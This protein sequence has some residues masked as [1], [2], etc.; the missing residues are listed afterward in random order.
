MGRKVHSLPLKLFICG[1]YCQ[2]VFQYV[3]EEKQ[4]QVVGILLFHLLHYTQHNTHFTVYY[5][6]QQ[7]TLHCVLQAPAIHT[8]LCIMSPSNT[9]FTVYYEP[10]QYTLHCVLRAPAIHTSL[11][12]M[13]PSNTHF[14]V[15]YEPQQYTLQC[16]LRAQYS[17]RIIY[18][19]TSVT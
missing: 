11:C 4:V 10:Q 18:Q 9:H 2:C 15:Y 7:Y 16:V 14:T 3:K 6:P 8:S 17:E 12:I 19:L 1:Q 13:S 5:E